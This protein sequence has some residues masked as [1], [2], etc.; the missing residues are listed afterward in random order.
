MYLLFLTAYNSHAL[1]PVI[2]S[3]WNMMVI[4]LSIEEHAGIRLMFVMFTVKLMF[5]NTT[6]LS[7]KE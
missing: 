5:I 3:V 7:F 6:L 2:I 4:S 1:F